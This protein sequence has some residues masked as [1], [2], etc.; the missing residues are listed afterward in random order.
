MTKDDF[1]ENMILPKYKAEV[2]ARYDKIQSEASDYANGKKLEEKGKSFI[3]AVY[4]PPIAL[5]LSLV[6]SIITLGKNML[7]ILLHIL[8]PCLLWLGLSNP[9]ERI[10]RL[11]IY[12]GFWLIYAIGTGYF[13]H[14][15]SNPYVETLAYKKYHDAAYDRA[16][17]M[18]MAIDGIVR[19]QPSIYIAGRAIEDLFEKLE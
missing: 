6:I 19:A 2:V 13:L 1:F 11:Y 16:P 8:G 17:V 7:F 14:S 18:T 5:G 3:R 4:I 15:Y 12:T 9:M 10:K